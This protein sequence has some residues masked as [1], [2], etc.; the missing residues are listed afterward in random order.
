MTPDRVTDEVKVRTWFAELGLSTGLKWSFGKTRV[1]PISC[2][3]ADNQ[4]PRTFKDRYHRWRKI[5]PLNEGMITSSYALG[6][7][8]SLYIHGGEYFYV[9]HILENDCWQRMRPAGGKYFRHRLLATV[10]CRLV[11]EP[12]FGSESSVTPESLENKQNQLLPPIM[13]GFLLLPGYGATTVGKQ[14][15]ET[16]K[17]FAP[18]VMIDGEVYQNQNSEINRHKIISASGP[19]I[20]KQGLQIQWSVPVENLFTVKIQ[21][22]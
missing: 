8:T 5:P 6:A 11:A 1:C 18:N 19:H 15:W 21:H 4:N 7:R 17:L 22:Y 9:S 12:I 20:N 14:R 2:L 10:M 16:S 13:N 3:N